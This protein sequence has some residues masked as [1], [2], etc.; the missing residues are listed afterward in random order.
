MGSIARARQYI[1]SAPS[2][3]TSAYVGIRR[4]SEDTCQ[5]EV[6]GVNSK[7]AAVHVERPLF[8]GPAVLHT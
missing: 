7:S 8:V 5:G 3:H 2:Q 1:S 6:D 4:H